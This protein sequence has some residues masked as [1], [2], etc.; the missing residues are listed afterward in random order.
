[1]TGGGMRSRGP[2]A[3]ALLRAAGRFVSP[4]GA[5]ARLLILIYHRVLPAADP[6][7]PGEVTVDAFGWQMETVARCVRIL[8]LGEAVER[9]RE[10]TLPARAA[11]ITF[12]DGYADNHELALPVLDRLGLPATFFV[13]T[14]RLG[15]WMWND[16]VIEAVRAARRPVDAGPLNLGRL[17][18]SGAAE[19][20]ATLRRILGTL[21]EM[22]REPRDAEVARLVEQT[23]AAL[24]EGLMMCPGQLRALCAAGMELG[25]HTVRHPILAHTNLEEARAEIADSRAALEEIVNAPVRLFA[26]PNGRPGIDYTT[27]HVRLVEELGFRG[28]VSTQWGANRTGRADPYQLRRFTPWDVSPDRFAARL[29]AQCVR[30]SARPDGMASPVA[31]QG[32]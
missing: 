13:T 31:G 7:Q 16:A 21:K 30:R 5:R 11:A 14:G 24:P 25:A 3:C 22:P 9:L 32:A 1:M 29:L 6:L 2:R 20:L 23:G 10:G 28:A 8:P 18:V 27:E 12:D 19:R 15:R 26:Y 17:G 4:P